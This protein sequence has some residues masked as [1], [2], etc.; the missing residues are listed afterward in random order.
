MSRKEEDF[1]RDWLAGIGSREDVEKK[2]QETVFILSPKRAPHP[3][4]N[5][6]HVFSTLRR[7]PLSILP[8]ED[9]HDDVEI[10]F[11]G[12]QTSNATPKGD[13]AHVFDGLQEGPLS[14][15]KETSPVEEQFEQSTNVIPLT[16]SWS[17]WGTIVAAAAVL[18]LLVQPVL[19]NPMMTSSQD[20]V[21]TK[22]KPPQKQMYDRD[23]SEK[24]E[25]QEEREV[26]SQSA[27]KETL[28]DK[29]KK[30]EKSTNYFVPPSPSKKAAQKQYKIKQED[31]VSQSQRGGVYSVLEAVEDSEVIA[32]EQTN[33]FDQSQEIQAREEK[34]MAEPNPISVQVVETRKGRRSREETA[35]KPDVL[36]ILREEAVQGAQIPRHPPFVHLDREALMSITQDADVQKVYWAAYELAIRFPQE[37]NHI[38]SVLRLKTTPSLE[39][40]Y[41]FVLLGDLYRNEGK[42]QRAQQA[43]REAMKIQ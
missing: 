13:I 25:P 3:R 20:P 11:S 41:L 28:S 30:K 42:D 18:L 35:K 31:A 32:M 23:L 19:N 24:E 33:A 27:A 1:V 39:Q 43:Y 38:E 10:L 15:K 14:I 5:I 40:K 21:A 22:S 26:I 17:V 12:A 8:Q 29:P 2:I 34:G 37:R 16:R 9:I 7:G 6:D 36:S 4:K